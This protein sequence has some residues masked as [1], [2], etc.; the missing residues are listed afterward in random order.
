[1]SEQI[2]SLAEQALM[3]PAPRLE[4]EREFTDWVEAEKFC[5]AWAGDNE[6]HAALVEDFEDNVLIVMD[7]KDA[8]A[9]VE[10]HDAEIQYDADYRKETR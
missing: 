9:Y 10:E 3:N 8:Q 5:D 1:M 2:E 7:I 4:G 6:A